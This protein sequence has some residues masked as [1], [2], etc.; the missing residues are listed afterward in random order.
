MSSKKYINLIV[1]VLHLQKVP[2]SHLYNLSQEIGPTLQILG[3]IIW[4]IT[5]MMSN[6]NSRRILDR[7]NI[8]KHS[9]SF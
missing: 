8:S 7:W 9:E 1:L 4:T 2:Q 5:V 6:E 3:S